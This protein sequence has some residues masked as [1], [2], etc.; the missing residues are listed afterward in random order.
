MIAHRLHATILA[1]SYGVPAVGLRWDD[2]LTAFFGS[3]GLEKHT[4]V[5]DHA[6]VERV[7]DFAWAALR[8]KVPPVRRE[9]VLARVADDI[10]HLASFIERKTVAPP[11]V[12]A[13]R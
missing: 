12:V 9:H 2:K 5:L 3:V 1:F 7:G 4:T 11:S 13:S 10:A 8:A 6:T